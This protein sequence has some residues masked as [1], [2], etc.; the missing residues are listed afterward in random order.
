MHHWVV[1]N[2]FVGRR[3]LAVPGKVVGGKSSVK[4]P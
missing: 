2:G 3:R 1:V 4:Y